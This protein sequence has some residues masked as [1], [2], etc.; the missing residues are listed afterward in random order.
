MLGV[1]VSD[2]SSEFYAHGQVQVRLLQLRV[3]RV[4]TMTLFYLIVFTATIFIMVSL[5][6]KKKEKAGDTIGRLLMSFAVLC[7][8][9]TVWTIIYL[10]ST[11]H[12]WA[13]LR[14]VLRPVAVYGQRKHMVPHVSSLFNAPLASSI[15][16]LRSIRR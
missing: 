1:I 6:V 9:I 14:V 16:P 10:V 5:V 13:D 11:P 12:L 7:I 4:S 15:I 2:K 8:T 3:Q